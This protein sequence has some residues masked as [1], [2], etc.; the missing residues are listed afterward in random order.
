VAYEGL[1]VV[2]TDGRTRTQVTTAR[3]VAFFWSPDG[4]RLAFAALD[5]GGNSL[6]WNVADASG[7]NARRLGPFTPTSEQIQLLAFFDQY[8]ISH[9][10][11]APDGS[12]LVYAVGQAGE[13]RMFGAPSTGTIQALATDGSRP[14]R[15]L[16][17]GNLVTMP[18]PAP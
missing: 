12:A 7:A 16:T 14:G 2:S 4:Q 3:V 10:L 5:A 13:P 15:T 8:A 9:G 18:V 1:E 11:W 6:A 17:G